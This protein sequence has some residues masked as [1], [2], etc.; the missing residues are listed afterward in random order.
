MEITKEKCNLKKI[1]IIIKFGL[2]WILPT[3]IAENKSKKYF[4]ELNPIMNNYDLSN[5]QHYKTAVM[6]PNVN[7]KLAIDTFLELYHIQHLHPKTLSHIINGDACMFDKHGR[8][9]R[10]IAPRKDLS[11]HK[12]NIMKI[13][14]IEKYI[15]NLKVIFPNT[16]LVEHGEHL[17]LW[18]ILPTSIDKSIVTVSLFTKLPYK[19]K[20]EIKH[21]EK[22]FQKLKDVVEKE[23]FPLG[24]NV[25]KGFYADPKRRLIFGKNEPALQHFHKTIRT[26]LK[27]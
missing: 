14:N 26:A 1:K 10:L 20:S 12:N 3:K 5:Y 21:W 4:E 8:H 19:T 16:V 15:I 2:I 25:Q 27:N 23:D 7:W 13:E 6:K 22:N 18:H 24:E 17:E 11:T 9:M